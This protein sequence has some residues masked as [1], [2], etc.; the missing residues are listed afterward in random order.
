INGVKKSIDNILSISGRGIPPEANMD[1][2]ASSTNKTIT[3]TASNNRFFTIS[4]GGQDSEAKI[5]EYFMDR[6]AR[7]KDIKIPNVADRKEYVEQILSG[8][9]VKIN[10][11][12][13][14][15]P[16]SSCATIIVKFNSYKAI[17]GAEALY[18]SGVIY[19]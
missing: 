17:T 4:G 6:L 10:I 8:S 1:A 12:T 18:K 7:E 14:M 13:E 2:I 19:P 5:F 11:I 3:P 16:C 9:K 15:S